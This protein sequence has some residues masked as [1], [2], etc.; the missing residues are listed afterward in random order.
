MKEQELELVTGIGLHGAISNKNFI[1]DFDFVTLEAWELMA[2][3]ENVSSLINLIVYKAIVHETA[4]SDTFLR[5]N[6]HG[7]TF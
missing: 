2:I 7:N 1:V 4:S 5:G 6:Y 3:F